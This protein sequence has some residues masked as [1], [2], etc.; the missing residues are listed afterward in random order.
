MSDIEGVL[1]RLEGTIEH[2]ALTEIE[3]AYERIDREQSVWYKTSRFTCPGGCGECC[4]HFEPDLLDSEA[5]YM[6]AWLLEH[7]PDTA[8]QVAEGKFPFANSGFCPFFNSSSPFHCSIYGGR[9]FICRLFGAGC[10]R[11][12]DRHLVWK[13]CRF[14]PDKVL[15][16]H[17]PP[18]E[19]R[20]YSEKELTDI[21]GAVPPDMQTLMKGAGTD[22]DTKLLR[23]TLPKIIRHLMFIIE[24][25]R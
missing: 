7:Q 3:E 5:L 21:F 1:G 2:Q 4:V 18:L 19:H 22:A 15:A 14:Y 20:Q 25:N 12:K 9:A 17:T 16:Q 11:A 13:P 24:I 8:C 6:G 10:T 23:D